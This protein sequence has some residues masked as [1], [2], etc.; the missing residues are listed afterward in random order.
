MTPPRSAVIRRAFEEA[1]DWFVSQVS[2]SLLVMDLPA[3]GEWTVRDLVGHT[4]RAL[5]TI[6]DYLTG[7]AANVDL[8]SPSDYFR[9]IS[10]ARADPGAVAQRGREAGLALGHDPAAAVA[11]TARRVLATVARHSDRACLG[12]PAGSI[13]LIDYL[14]TRTFELTVHTIDLSVA[15]GLP[16]EPPETAAA[17]SLGLVSDLAVH[18]G[19]AA[20]LLLA[21]TGRGL[22]SGAYTVF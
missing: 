17:E 1:T 19:R 11:E 15:L 21:A 4:S 10:A 3:L 8:G 18:G 9:Q 6:E 16:E 20:P 2:A 7:A 12:T 22:S 14:P 5:L 13:H